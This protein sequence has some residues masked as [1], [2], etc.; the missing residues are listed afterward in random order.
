MKTDEQGAAGE[1]VVGAGPSRVGWVEVW[2]SRG[3][4][5]GNY[6]CMNAHLLASLTAYTFH[7]F[8]IQHV[9]LQ[10]PS[11]TDASAGC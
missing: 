7:F 5:R 6:N 10:G 4:W 1:K 11:R 3:R 2:A 9:V 8:T